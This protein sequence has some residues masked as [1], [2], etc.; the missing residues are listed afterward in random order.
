MLPA[1]GFLGREQARIQRGK[2]ESILELECKPAVVSFQASI[3][4]LIH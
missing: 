3:H 1:M 2:Q 4:T